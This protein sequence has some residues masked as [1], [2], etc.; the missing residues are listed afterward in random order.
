MNINF[1][2]DNVSASDRLEQ[3][4]T[5]KISKLFDRYDFLVR[6]D[7]FFK[8]ENT[9][10]PETGLICNIRLSAPGPRLFAEASNDTFETSIRESVS[11]LERQLKKRKDKMKS[12]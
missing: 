11:E 8:K 4:A 2:Y 12:H 1:E 3:L 5:D 10:S 6:A 7:V 9:S